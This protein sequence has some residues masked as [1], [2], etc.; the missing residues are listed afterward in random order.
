MIETP[1]LTLRSWRDADRDA[2]A[3]MGRDPEV[4]VYLGPVHS[5]AESDAAI[6]RMIGF[7]ATHGFTFWAVVRRGTGD[8]LGMCGLKPGATGTPIEGEVEI[9][10]RLGRAHWGHGYA[11]EAA[12][13][14]L[15][16][17]W[18]NTPAP[19]IAAITTESNARSWRLMERLGMVR[20]PALG[21]R[22]P[23]VPEDSP[24]KFHVTYFAHRPGAA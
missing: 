14:A 18:A 21:F 9:G 10:W 17:G 2:I 19:R 13:A 1:R 4:M 24:L 7:E 6:D 20:D 3:E 5:R 8:L 11:H 16:F 15:A 12:A 23:A 22:H